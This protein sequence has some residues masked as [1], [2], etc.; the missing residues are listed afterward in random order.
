MSHV[1]S[2]QTAVFDKMDIRDNTKFK[3]LNCGKQY[4][5]QNNRV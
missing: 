1:Y 2:F 4:E 3:G 5:I